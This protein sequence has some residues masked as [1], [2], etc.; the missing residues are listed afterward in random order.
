MTILTN[1]T[2]L[3]LAAALFALG[4]AKGG[5]DSDFTPAADNARKALEAALNHWQA[6]NPPGTIPGT[7]P[8]VEVLDSKWKS[9]AKLTAYEILAEEAGAGPRTFTVRL[10]L[11]KGTEEARYIVSGIDPLWVYREEDYK[12]LSGAGM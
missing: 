2:R 5:K 9:G 1:P 6:G 11:G 7:K 12:K 10:T 8:P 4:C 3:L